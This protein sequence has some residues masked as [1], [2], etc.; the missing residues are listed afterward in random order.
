[1]IKRSEKDA[2]TVI[3]R[4]IDE[5]ILV[6][7]GGVTRPLERRVASLRERIRGLQF[8]VLQVSRRVGGGKQRGQ[9]KGKQPG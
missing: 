7:L 5:R 2:R 4:W 1:L 3:E 9:G 6:A 8:R